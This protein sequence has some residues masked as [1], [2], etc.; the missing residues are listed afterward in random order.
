MLIVQLHALLAL[1]IKNYVTVPTAIIFLLAMCPAG[2]D[3]VWNIQ[4]TNTPAGERD[5]QKCPRSEV[6]IGMLV[7]MLSL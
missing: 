1:I 6:E 2:P 5:M 4:W 7:N 3:P